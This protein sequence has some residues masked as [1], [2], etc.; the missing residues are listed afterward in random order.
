LNDAVLCLIVLIACLKFSTFLSGVSD[1]KTGL[2]VAVLRA[3]LI[4][5]WKQ[6]TDRTV[7]GLPWTELGHQ[8]F[9]APRQITVVVVAWPNTLC[10]LRNLP[11]R[12]SDRH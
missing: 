11:I 4:D 6:A 5:G 9:R 1:D 12:A 3:P 2:R 7:I 8:I 10:D